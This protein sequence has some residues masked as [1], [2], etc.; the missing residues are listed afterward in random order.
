MRTHTGEKPYACDEEGCDYK[1]TQKGNIKRHKKHVHGY[2]TPT[3]EKPYAC[4]EE[5]CDYKARESK[6]LN[7]HIYE[8]HYNKMDLDVDKLPEIEL[9]EDIEP[10]YY[11]R[12]PK[13]IPKKTLLSVFK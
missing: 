13:D 4:D 10:A 9:E 5:G 12:Y 3:N 1:S 8:K 6:I 7:T 11:E 2:V